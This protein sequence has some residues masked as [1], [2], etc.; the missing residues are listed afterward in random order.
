MG[1]L[2]QAADGPHVIDWLF[3]AMTKGTGL[4]V[5]IHHDHHLLGIHHCAN[6]YGQSG[7]RNQVDI[8]VEETTVG[9]DGI[10]GEGLLASAAL[11]AGAWLVEGDMA[12]GANAAHE[13]VDTTCCLYGFLVV[14]ALC[15]QILSIA[16]EDMDVLFLDVLMSMWL[17]KLFHMKLW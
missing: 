3:D 16:V 5:A 1:M 12:V 15:L 2:L 17:K 8:I 10:G 9:D 4:V 11:Q 7:F 14:L 13:Q 6:T